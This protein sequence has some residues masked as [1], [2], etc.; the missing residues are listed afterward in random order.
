MS[1]IRNID[2]SDAIPIRFIMDRNLSSQSSES[3]INSNDSDSVCRIC[4]GHISPD[5]IKRFCNCTGHVG[6]IHKLCLLRW[7]FQRDL[8]VCEICNYR[9]DIIEIRGI[10]YIYLLLVFIIVFWFLFLG[11]FI[12]YRR[13]QQ[14]EF[15]FLVTFTILLIIFLNAKKREIF[16]E[17]K[18]IDVNEMRTDHEQGESESITN[19]IN[20]NQLSNRQ[21]TNNLFGNFS[22]V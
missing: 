12:L 20:N 14:I 17:L 7:I 2:S 11:I 3:S 21:Q 15:I 8:P 5:N 19:D 9:Y 10:N 4:L 6:K 1:L 18:K 13:D 22:Y 16:Y